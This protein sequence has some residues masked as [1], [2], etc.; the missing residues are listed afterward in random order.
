MKP[1]KGYSNLKKGR[2][3]Q[4]GFYYHLVFS[5]KCRIPYFLKLDYSRKFIQI[6]KADGD[7]GFTNT[8]CFC[9]MPD[10]VH[11]LFELK[12]GTLQQAPKRVKSIFS[13]EVRSFA[14]NDGFYGHTIRSDE[15]LINVA[16]YIVAN[17]LGAGLVKRVGDYPHWDSAWLD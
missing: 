10:H 11:W 13:C 8:L 9:V 6:L 12:K 2:H 16:R 15:S 4:V 1:L 17:P 14:W 7:L 3:S 5:A